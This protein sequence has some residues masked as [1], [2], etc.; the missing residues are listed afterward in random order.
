ME[1]SNDDQALLI[2]IRKKDMI[3]N[4]TSIMAFMMLEP[5]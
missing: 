5:L 4:I 2:D 3:N 1:A